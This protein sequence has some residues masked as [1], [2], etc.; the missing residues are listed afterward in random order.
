MKKAFPGGPGKNR[1]VYEDLM[2]TGTIIRYC[3][4]VLANGIYIQYHLC[5]CM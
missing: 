5:D 1:F 3:I 2:V 4:T